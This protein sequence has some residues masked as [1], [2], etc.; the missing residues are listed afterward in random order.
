MSPSTANGTP[1]RS[2]ARKTS[3][4]HLQDALK[5]L[6]KAREKATEEG[7]AAIEEAMDRIREASKEIAD[8]GQDQLTEWEDA[9]DDAAES[10]RRE[11]GRIA[12]HAQRSEEA[13][14]GMSAEIA[15]RKAELTA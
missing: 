8:R 14:A 10:A 3:L 11:L 2:H 9:L 1:A 7:A 4:D 5:D 13:L 15:K 6:S 12:V